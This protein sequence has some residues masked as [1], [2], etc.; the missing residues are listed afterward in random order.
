MDNNYIEVWREAY[1]KMITDTIK[2]IA[3]A[4][5]QYVNRYWRRTKF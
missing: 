3:L 4:E 2:A 5:E 1:G